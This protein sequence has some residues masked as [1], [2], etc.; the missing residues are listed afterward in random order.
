MAYVS[1]E[2]LLRKKSNFIKIEMNDRNKYLVHD[3]Q[4][5]LFFKSGS[6]INEMNKLFNA[7]WNKGE[8]HDN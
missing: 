8:K 1:R 2:R 3:T 6:N 4:L 5:H 7:Y